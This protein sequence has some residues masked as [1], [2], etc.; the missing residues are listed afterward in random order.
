MNPHD[1]VAASS[2]HDI[3]I[4]HESDDLAHRSNHNERCC[5]VVHLNWLGGRTET[6]QPQTSSQ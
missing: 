3:A 2:S 6:G 5:A 1:P 4:R